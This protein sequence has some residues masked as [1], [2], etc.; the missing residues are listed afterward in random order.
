MTDARRVPKL[1]ALNDLYAA[2]AFKVVGRSSLARANRTAKET[3]NHC[4]SDIENRAVSQ[5]PSTSSVHRRDLGSSIRSFNSAI[6]PSS[7]RRRAIRSSRYA[8]YESS[9][10]GRGSRGPYPT[11]V[12]LRRY[13]RTVLRDT[14]SSRAICRIVFPCRASTLIS[15]TVSKLCNGVAQRDASLPNYNRVS[16]TPT[17]GVSFTPALT[18]AFNQCLRLRSLHDAGRR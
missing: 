7:H 3:L 18:A 11:A 12:S 17:R 13:L 4:N 15:T 9:L 14:P 5:W 6:R 10:V 16:F 8:W 1:R 2:T